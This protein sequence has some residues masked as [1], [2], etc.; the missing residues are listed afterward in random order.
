MIQ[1]LSDTNLWGPMV[2]VSVGTL[3]LD[4]WVGFESENL[5]P[6]IASSGRRFPAESAFRFVRAVSVQ[7]EGD[8]GHVARPARRAI[9]YGARR[10]RYRTRRKASLSRRKPVEC[11]P[12]DA[13]PCPPR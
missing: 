10:Q 8:T 6:A 13:R 5:W 9:L 12:W 3:A 4:P 2:M 11:R 1:I 7:S